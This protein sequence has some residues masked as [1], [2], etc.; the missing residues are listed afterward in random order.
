MGF[1]TSLDTFNHRNGTR[2]DCTEAAVITGKPDLEFANVQYVDKDPRQYTK[3]RVA[4][5]EK[6]V[7]AFHHRTHV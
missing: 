6:D 4:E 5:T 2:L 1:Y 3:I 7:T